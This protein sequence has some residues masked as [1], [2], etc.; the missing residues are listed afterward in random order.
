MNMR[1]LR[2]GGE[3]LELIAAA[4]AAIRQIPPPSR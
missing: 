4:E 3:T 1:H 2:F